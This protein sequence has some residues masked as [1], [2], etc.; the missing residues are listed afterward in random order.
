MAVMYTQRRVI[1][2][3]LELLFMVNLGECLHAGSAAGSRLAEAHETPRP[4]WCS[5]TPLLS[6]V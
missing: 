4:L 3:R 5:V 6:S 1:G 2:R